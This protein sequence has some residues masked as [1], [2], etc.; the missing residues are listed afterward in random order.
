MAQRML[1]L[2]KKIG[3]Q[4]GDSNEYFA[5][6]SNTKTMHLRWSDRLKDYVLVLNFSNLKKNILNRKEWNK[7]QQHT[8]HINNIFKNTS[9]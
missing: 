2:K 4:T 1:D 9:Q 3:T 6:L 7:L 8:H 5:S